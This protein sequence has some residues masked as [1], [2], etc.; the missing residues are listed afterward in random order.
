MSFEAVL[1]NKEI[2]FVV[3]EVTVITR[4]SV[5]VDDRYCGSG[6]YSLQSKNSFTSFINV[7]NIALEQ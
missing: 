4:R 3:F 7:I 2:E 1:G 6:S 5:L